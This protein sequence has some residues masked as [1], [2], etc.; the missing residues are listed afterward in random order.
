MAGRDCWWGKCVF[1]SWT[2]LY[3]RWRTQSPTKLLDEIGHLI[4]HYPVREIFDDTGCF[5]AGDWLR[6]FCEGMVERGYH[7]RVVMG[8][9][10]IPGVLT[11][12]LYDLMGRAGFR[13]VLFGLESA[14]QS[15]LDRIRT[16][17]K[18]PGVSSYRM[19]DTVKSSP[20]CRF[21]RKAR[22]TT[23]VP[24]ASF[25]SSRRLQSPE[26]T[27]LPPSAVTQVAMRLGRSGSG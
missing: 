13:F 27:W 6:E 5:P 26:W 9:N 25:C 16:C 10:M 19:N 14:D 4:E 1:C 15:T 23:E 8:C 12:K 22:K 24:L 11:Q 3:N 20:S 7:K 2:T 18:A 21:H 17:G